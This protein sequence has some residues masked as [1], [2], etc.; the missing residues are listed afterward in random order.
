MDIQVTLANGIMLM[1]AEAFV[2]TSRHRSPSY[3]SDA[4]TKL[5]LRSRVARH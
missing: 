2:A 4:P 5:E 3:V 1:N